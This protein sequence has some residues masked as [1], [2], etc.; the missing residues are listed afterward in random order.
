MM[1][2]IKKKGY[3][4]IEMML[5]IA[6][7]ALLMPAVFSILYVIMQQQVKIYEL[8]E[9]KRQGDYVMQ[10]MKEKIMRDAVSLR[11]DDD[12]IFANVA[13][14]T[15]I[16]NNTGTSFTSASNGQDFVF[17]NDLNNPF[18]YVQ[19]G[20]TIRFREIGTP[21]VDA[22]LS[23]NRVI[24]S[25]FQITCAVKSTYTDPV[26]SFSYTATFNRAVPNPQ[27]GTTQLQYQTKI[28][29]RI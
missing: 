25:N 8:T 9:T 23:S 11:R 22:A 15:N 13:V 4:L 29:L 16:C 17:L 28:K 20:N 21:N 14:I 10:L 19:S 7:V 26:V 3:T 24:I 12:G 6:L 2:Q 1:Q 27:L 18:Q 5:V